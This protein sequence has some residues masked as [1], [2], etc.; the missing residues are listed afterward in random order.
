[1]KKE[2]QL[3]K[4]RRRSNADRGRREA[5][6]AKKKGNEA[7][8]QFMKHEFTPLNRLGGAT[9]KKKGQKI[10]AKRNTSKSSHQAK[11]KNAKSIIS[12]M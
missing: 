12:S 5:E 2:Q 8:Q 3:R 1:M 9:K 11:E 6:R 10:T 4:E 7:K